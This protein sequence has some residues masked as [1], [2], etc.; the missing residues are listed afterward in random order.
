MAD[1][2]EASKF[3]IAIIMYNDN[4]NN[5]RTDNSNNSN[6]D[7]NKSN[8]NKVEINSKHMMIMAIM[9]SIMILIGFGACVLKSYIVAGLN[10]VYGQGG[11]D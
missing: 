9:S 2:L 4:S 5:P 10:N 7:T 1:L 6:T 11:T 8:N 3:V